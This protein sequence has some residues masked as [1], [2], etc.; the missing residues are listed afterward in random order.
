MIESFSPVAATDSVYGYELKRIYI[1]SPK[2]LEFQRFKALKELNGCPAKADPDP[3][4]NQD[5]KSPSPQHKKEV[6]QGSKKAEQAANQ[7]IVGIFAAI[8][9]KI[10]QL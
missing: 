10:Y 4:E 6:K 7:K 9:R 1:H 2:R 3:A 5:L 8:F